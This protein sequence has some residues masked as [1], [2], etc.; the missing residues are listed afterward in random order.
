MAVPARPRPC[1]LACRSWPRSRPRPLAGPRPRS[2]LPG[3]RVWPPSRPPVQSHLCGPGMA[4][5]GA[6]P[7]IRP[8]GPASWPRGERLLPP[9]S[10]CRSGLPERSLSPRLSGAS[11]RRAEPR[12]RPG[13]SPRATSRR[14]GAVPLRPEPALPRPEPVPSW[15]GPPAG[16]PDGPPGTS[17]ARDLRDLVEPPRPVP[18]PRPAGAAAPRRATRLARTGPPHHPART[19]ATSGASAT[20]A[21]TAARG[22]AAPRRATRPAG[23]AR[24]T[25]RSTSATVEPPRPVPSPRPAAPLRPDAPPG[26]PERPAAPPGTPPRPAPPWPGLPPSRRRGSSPTTYPPSGLASR[27]GTITTC[28]VTAKNRGPLRRSGPQRKMSGGVLLSHAVPRA[29]PSALKGLTS[30]FGMGPGVSPSPWPPKLY[31]DVVQPTA[32]RE[33]HSGRKQEYE[34]E[35]K[36]L[37]LLV[38]V[39]STRCRASTSGLSTQSSSWGP[40]RVNPEGD[41]ILRR[42]SR[43]DAFSGYPFRT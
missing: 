19:S 18:S 17:A 24:R 27:A 28:R 42:A 10:P 20:S 22:A 3:R 9:A 32:S 16:R 30:G 13:S 31:G 33:P 43:L 23:T 6:Q 1:L 29:V 5:A 35:A 41:L 39:S 15:P 8:A 25:T 11:P 14:P 34:V 40:Y 37:G 36:P 2:R 12:G 38:P 7:E 26:R 21:I 4:C